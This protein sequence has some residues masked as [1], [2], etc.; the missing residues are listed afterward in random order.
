M[1]RPDHI[2]S[3]ENLVRRFGGFTAVDDVT[4]GVRKG[5]IH[6]VIGPNGAGK[7]TFFNLLT[8]FLPASEGRIRFDGHDITHLAADRVAGLG[9]VRS[10]QI[11]AIFPT[12]TL[13]ENVRVAL[14]RQDGQSW[15]FWRSGKRLRR[16][17]AR[18]LEL[19][20]R[21]GLADRAQDTAGQL[22]YGRKRSLEIATALA[23]DPKLLLLD[24]PMAGMAAEEIQRIEDLI[25]EIA[26]GC[27]ILMVEHNL[28]VVASL[29]DE[30]TVLAQGSLLAQGSYAEVSSNPEVI[31]A[32]IGNEQGNAHV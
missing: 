16:L 13:L 25:R 2:L 10:F 18:A 8:R 22:P 28:S 29:A 3:C 19:L 6:A 23:L 11:S 31:R 9:M 7:T 30:I 1:D 26:Q 4:L 17:N 32:Y 27:T 20:D 15:D 5:T 12:L 21:V 14:Q 24:E